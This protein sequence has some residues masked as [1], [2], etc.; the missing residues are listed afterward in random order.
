MTFLTQVAV[1][2]VGNMGGGML[3]RLR[4][5]GWSVAVHDIDPQVQSQAV[6]LG[7]VACESAMEATRMLAPDGVID[8]MICHEV[9]HLLHMNHSPQYWQSV[10]KVCPDLHQNQTK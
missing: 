4:G 10:A 5:L 8:Y 6:A 3:T 9:C 7:A 2:G 1:V